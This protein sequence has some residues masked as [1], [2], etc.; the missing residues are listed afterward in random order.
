M[1][2]QPPL[3]LV[4]N[5]YDRI[6]QYPSGV[7]S[8]AAA[9]VG[10]E[11]NYVAD[12]RRERTYFQAA[13]AAEFNGVV[14]DIG[15]GNT[16]AVD[17]IFIDR[18][19]NLWGKTIQIVSRASDA[20]FGTGGDDT[21]ELTVPA[22]TVIGGDPSSGTMAVTEE[23]ALYAI[24]TA[25]PAHRFFKTQ[26]VSSWAPIITGLILGKRVQLARFT[27]RIDEDAGGR[28]ER[29][30]ESDAGYKAVDR[31]YDWRTLTLDIGLIGASEYDATMRQ[32]R[33]L[34]FSMN[35]P[36]VVAMDYGTYPERA[37]MYQFDGRS[38][39]MGKERVYRS[40]SIPMRELYPVIR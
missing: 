19:H 38:W 27:K 20:L 24:F 4:D 3:I 25:K 28:T 35:Q 2:P 40:G 37:W 15:A 1:P 16:R 8:G 33:A 36:A 39:S 11:V 34:L 23:G 12:Y 7:L 22:S 13:A 6:R 21:I 30:Q 26:V 32:L 10:R 31:V 14:A 18:G 9:V 17:G 5:V 29:S